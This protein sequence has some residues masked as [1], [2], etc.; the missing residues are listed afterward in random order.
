MLLCA[1]G[2]QIN[3]VGQNWFAAANFSGKDWIGELEA[4]SMWFKLKFNIWLCV[5]Y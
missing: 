4:F 1:A 2:S 5:C 3:I